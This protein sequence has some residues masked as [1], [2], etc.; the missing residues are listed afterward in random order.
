MR[1][2]QVQAPDAEGAGQA[3]T[4]DAGRNDLPSSLPE[5][6]GPEKTPTDRAG[7]PP[8]LFR[9]I[10]IWPT[11]PDQL[12]AAIMMR[13]E[14]RRRGATTDGSEDLNPWLML[15]EDIRAAIIESI[16]SGM[17]RTIENEEREL[18]LLEVSMAADPR[19]IEEQVDADHE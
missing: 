15:P 11:L 5:Q 3:T 19:R 13:A 1:V 12:R 17:K 14:G 4:C 18:K 2:L 10:A 6:Y 8:D 16:N 7:L 9:L